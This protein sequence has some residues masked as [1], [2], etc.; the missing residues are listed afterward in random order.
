MFRLGIALL[1]L[2][3]I[4]GSPTEAAELAGKECKAGDVDN[5]WRDEQFI[6]S[7]EVRVELWHMDGAKACDAIAAVMTEMARIE[8][9]MSPHR[10]DSVL[11]DL[12]RNAATR[13]VAVG[14]ELFNLVLESVGFSR[15]THG[16]FDITRG[17]AERHHHV[18]S[19][20]TPADVAAINF[21]D[22]ELNGHNNSIRF[23]HEAVQVD[24][25]GIDKGY[26]VDRGVAVLMERGMTNALVSVGGDTRIV[27]DR[28]GQ[29][30]L[31]GI[32]RPNDGDVVTLPLQDVSISTSGDYRQ[33]G[34]NGLFNE[35]IE[36]QARGRQA[37][38]SVTILGNRAITTD[39]LSTSVFLLGVKQG[40]ELINSLPGFDAIVVDGAG[41][42]YWSD[43]LQSLSPAGSIA[44]AGVESP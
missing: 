41:E 15:L 42:M 21:R 40:L 36:P 1:I 32:R 11:S 14:D 26:A 8:K 34:G 9:D 6:M 30:W 39:V 20:V 2:L 44:A 27:G 29:P 12:N 10:E 4:F 13:A 22:L 3:A 19:A 24:L 5:W 28:T 33:R 35:V 25:G 18:D 43:G 16:A 38:A 23:L 7:R 17:S 31:V 37:V